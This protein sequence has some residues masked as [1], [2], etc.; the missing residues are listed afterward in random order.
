METLASASS[1]WF[2]LLLWLLSLNQQ[3]A[4]LHVSCRVPLVY[5][6][7]SRPFGVW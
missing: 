1:F 5:M 2:L 7:A 4:F 6:V 3:M